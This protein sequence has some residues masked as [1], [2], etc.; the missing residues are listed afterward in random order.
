[1]YLNELIEMQAAA[2]A[3]GGHALTGPKLLHR[4]RRLHD[5]VPHRRQV[6]RDLLGDRVDGGVPV[7][8]GVRRVGADRGHLKWHRRLLPR[9]E[10]SEMLPGAG[11]RQP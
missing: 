1:M 8:D 2:R 9:C 6:G 11:H 4:R 5:R 7:E 3:A 10:E